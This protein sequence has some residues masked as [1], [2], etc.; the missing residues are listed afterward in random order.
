M[1]VKYPE[2]VRFGQRVAE[3]RKNAQL[4]QESLALKS[5][6]NRT[7]MGAVERGEKTP[8]LLIISKIAHAFDLTLKQLFDYE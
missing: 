1:I 7:Y 2:N 8:S 5:G 4:S 6:I 3:L